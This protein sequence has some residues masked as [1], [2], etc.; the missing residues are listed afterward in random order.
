M[1]KILLH[2][3]FGYGNI[4]DEAICASLIKELEELY[5]E[6][7]E[8]VI[9]SRDLNRSSNIH[10]K[11]SIKDK[12][13][14]KNSFFEILK[15]DKL[16]FCGGGKY[17]NY[18]HRRMALLALLAKVVGKEV[19][20][21]A[22]GFYPFRWGGSPVL[23]IK[24]LPIQ[25]LTTRILTKAAFKF[26]NKVTVRD[27]FS[28]ECLYLSGIKKIKIEEDLALK[29]KPL[30]IEDIKHVLS[31]YNI[32]LEKKTF[33]IGLNLRTLHP[34][35]NSNVTT[36]LQKI[37]KFVAQKY[38]VEI[39]FVPF[40]YGSSPDRF[41]DNDITIA[42][43]LKD[44]VGENFKII[45]RELK[46]QEMLT[47]FRLFDMFIGMR[48]HSIVFAK[49]MNIP[50]IVLIYDIKVEEFLKTIENSNILL[51][52]SIDEINSEKTLFKLTQTIINTIKTH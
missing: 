34:E 37:L 8:I 5:R 7:C 30:N 17:G 38:A 40:G 36:A 41:F 28:R 43:S 19:E 10:S 12:T 1:K 44:K 29:L 22:I 20:F 32:Y 33:R 16:I 35:I 50:M 24:P 23:R 3:Y 14:F 4:G 42:K 9:L 6:K 26:A 25:S 49:K 48:F 39:V 18:T 21:R 51:N 52:I 46:P 2:G 45:E 15:Y 13:D 11:K 27:K 31:E 47:F